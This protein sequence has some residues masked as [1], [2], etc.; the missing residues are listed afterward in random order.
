MM[1]YLHECTCNVC[2]PSTCRVYESYLNPLKLELQIVVGHHE[3][4][5]N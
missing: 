3:G 2:V 4:A 5:G 1:F